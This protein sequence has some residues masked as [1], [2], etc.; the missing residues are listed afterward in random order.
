M[1][2]FY[3]D[4]DPF[5]AAECMID[6]HVVK[7]RAESIQMIA[8]VHKKYGVDL[9]TEWPRNST[10]NPYKGGFDNHPCTKWAG[11]TSANYNWL[12]AHL[13][14]L[15]AEYDYRY[16]NKNTQTS[17]VL[18]YL[19]DTHHKFI[20]KLPQSN[21]ITYPQLAMPLIYYTPWENPDPVLSY[22]AY[23]NGEKK[24]DKN[25]KNMAKYT[26]REKPE[27]MN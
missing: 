8:S 26:K 23:Y 22:R 13:S 24:Q 7:M 18:K 16:C 25:G 19:V 3:L 21:S 11:A 17:V 15:E 12:L 10:G 1:N 9:S 14:G 4:E 5:R 27:W 6:K 2:I 20:T